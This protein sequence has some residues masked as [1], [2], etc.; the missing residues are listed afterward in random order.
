MSR[1][2]KSLIGTGI[3]ALVVLAGLFVLGRNAERFVNRV[4]PVELP[5]VSERARELHFSSD[6]I[7]LHA[8]SLLSGRD[9]LSRS[10]VGHVDLPRLREGGVGIQFFTAATKS[11]IALDVHQTRADAIDLMTIGGILQLSPM[12]WSGSFKRAL[13]QSDSLARFV[14]ASGGKLVPIRT[15][16]ELER[17]LKLREKDPEVVGAILGI[18]GAHALEADLDNFERLYGAG[19]RMIG[20]THFFDNAFSGSA[21]G[22]EKGGLTEL[23]RALLRRMAERGVLLDLAHLSPAG[24]DDALAMVTKPTVVSHGGVK[25]TCDNPRNIS[26][27][28]IRAIAA[29]GGVVG[30]GYWHMAICGRELR[31]IVAAMRHVVGL[32]GDD[33]VALGSDYDG[34]TNVGFDTSQLPALTQ[35]LLDAGFSDASV[36][37]I[38]GGNVLRVLRETLPD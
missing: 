18:E 3:G 28:H 23:G 21:H 10:D 37:K 25:G 38:L 14:E 16:R 13:R 7:D 4:T 29:G 24:I 30:I 35:A 34:A 6:V 17:V 26:D 1:G 20:P 15:R 36:R 27:R 2:R 5:V 8:D 12:A 33:H 22:I 9:L 31:H 19:F 11:P 32:V